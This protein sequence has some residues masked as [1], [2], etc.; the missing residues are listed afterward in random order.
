[1]HRKIPATIDQSDLEVAILRVLEQQL[2][3]LR[4]DPPADS[5]HDIAVEYAAMRG[6]TQRFGISRPTQYV[7]LGSGQIA[8]VKSGGRTLINVASVRRY[9]ARCP[10]AAIAPPRHRKPL[11]PEPVPT[12]TAVGT[13]QVGQRRTRQAGEGAGVLAAPS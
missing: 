7:L 12:P 3:L 10:R 5:S 4:P 11:Q 13:K 2:G 1:M 9:L 8:A 6:I